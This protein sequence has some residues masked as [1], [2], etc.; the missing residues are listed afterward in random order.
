MQCL[1][2]CASSQRSFLPYDFP[3]KTSCETGEWLYLFI[4]FQYIMIGIQVYL[5]C[6]FLYSFFETVTFHFY[7][8]SLCRT[9]E[10]GN[11]V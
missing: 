5:M 1:F 10:D 11:D 9:K 3:L 2:H 8:T 4:G 7:E 6:S